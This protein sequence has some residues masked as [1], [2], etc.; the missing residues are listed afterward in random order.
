MVDERLNWKSHISHICS[1]ISKTTGIIAKARKFFGLKTL[2]TLYYAF[3]YP[4]LLYNAIIWGTATKTVLGP[5]I[6]LQKRAIRLVHNLKY[7][8]STTNV[9]KEFKYLKVDELHTYMTSLFM[10]KFVKK[11]LPV[12]FD[13]YFISN[14]MIHY[15]STRQ[16]DHFH[17]PIFKTTLGNTSIKKKGVFIWHEVHTIYL[18]VDTYYVFKQCMIWWIISKRSKIQ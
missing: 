17:V 11:Q 12:I 1:K 3:V 9:F 18:Q 7:R 8:D 6:L 2:Q 10:Y 13:G 14:P 4:Y 5:L 15:Y 16:A